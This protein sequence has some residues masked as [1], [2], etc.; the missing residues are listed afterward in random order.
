MPTVKRFVEED[1]KDE[2]IGAFIRSVLSS[3]DKATKLALSSG[4]TIR[5]DTLYHVSPTLTAAMQVMPNTPVLVIQVIPDAGVCWCAHLRPEGNV[6]AAF[7]RAD[8]LVE[9]WEEKVTRF[10]QS[11]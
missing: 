11:K 4:V 7:F 10:R 1:I 6:G 2:E 8:Q 3:M 9:E 5:E